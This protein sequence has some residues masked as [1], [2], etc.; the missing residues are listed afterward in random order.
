MNNHYHFSEAG[1]KHLGLPVFKDC[2]EA[3]KVTSCDASVIYVPPAFAAAAII[4]AIK[5]EIEFIVCI[6]D[7]IP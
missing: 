3:K 6:T 1:S 5:A 4:E 2:F 7:G